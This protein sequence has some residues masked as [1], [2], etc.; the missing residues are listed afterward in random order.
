MPKDIVSGD[1]YW[2]GEEN[3]KRIIAAIDCTGHGVPGAFMSM[4]GNAF[5]NEIVHEK[6][7]T[8]PALILY[9]LRTRVIHSLKQEGNYLDNKDRMDIAICVFDKDLT[10]LEFAGA[11]N[12]LWLIRGR[13]LRQINAD[14]QPIGSSGKELKDFTNHKVQLEKNDIIYIFTDGFPDQFGGEKG[15][16][17]NYKPLQEL[18]KNHSDKPMLEVEKVLVGKFHEWKGD[19]Q[20]VDDVCIIGIRV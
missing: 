17:F 4:V 16:K 20:Q 3:N 11:N 1:F 8:T 13:E 15:K 12:P 19:L 5:L 14:K 2:F 10:N 7:I 18:L 9:E 6:E